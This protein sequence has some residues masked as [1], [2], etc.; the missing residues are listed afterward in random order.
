MGEV[1]WCCRENIPINRNSV[2]KSVEWKTSGYI[3]ERENGL[4]WLEQRRDD[5]K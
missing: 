3:R 4:V 2:N 1:K 5:G